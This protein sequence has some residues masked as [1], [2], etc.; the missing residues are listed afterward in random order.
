V[1]KI[2]LISRLQAALPE[3]NLKVARDLPE[4]RALV[5]ELRD[6]QASFSQTGY[7]RFGARQGKHDDLVLA[8]A[9]ALWWSKESTRHKWRAREFP[10]D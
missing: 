7:A 6:F 10:F 9:I 3:G 1:A 4:T 2:L 8:C 5:E